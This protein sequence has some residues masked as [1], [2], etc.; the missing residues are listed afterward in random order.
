MMNENFKNIVIS[1]P[2]SGTIDLIYKYQIHAHPDKVGYEYKDVQ[3]YTFR[4]KGGIMEKLFE[5]EKIITI[6]PYNIDEIKKYNLTSEVEHRV[7]KYVEER[8]KSF[9]F[10]HK[11]INYKFYILNY[12]EDLKHNP[13]KPCQN[14]HCYITLDE[15]HSGKEFVNTIKVSESKG[16]SMNQPN[17][18]ENLIWTFFF[19][20]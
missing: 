18:K 4:K 13:K 2:A 1:I 10:E 16:I 6:N 19:K 11:G 12:K 5:I 20:S 15:L 9:K 7:R 17:N 3:Y 14:N 8:L